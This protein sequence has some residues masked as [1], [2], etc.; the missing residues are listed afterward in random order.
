[1]VGGDSEEEDLMEKLGIDMDCVQDILAAFMK[2]KP[3][4]ELQAQ[5]GTV[6]A[7]PATAPPPSEG[8]PAKIEL[9]AATVAEPAQEAQAVQAEVPAAAGQAHETQVVEAAE[10]PA[11]ADALD[12]VPTP[13]KQAKQE[14]S[15]EAGKVTEPML[16]LL[17]ASRQRPIEIASV[18]SQA[19]TEIAEEEDGKDADAAA[20]GV[21]QVLGDDQQCKI[22]FSKFNESELRSLCDTVKEGDHFRSFVSWMKASHMLD[23]NFSDSWGGS[24]KGADM[25]R[26]DLSSFANFA[27]E[28]SVEFDPS[29]VLSQQKP[30]ETSPEA[31]GFGVGDVFAIEADVASIQ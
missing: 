24:S 16:A 27:A 19:P 11:L 23:G 6:V 9:P 26:V 30:P 20:A 5:S 31:Q 18:D 10:P 12:S 3:E 13:C 1:M 8:E 22:D 2:M 29:R 14:P 25:L 4:E 15:C 21:P 17:E 7:G 28:C